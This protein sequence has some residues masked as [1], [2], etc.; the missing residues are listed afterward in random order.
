MKENIMTNDQ[1][2][3]LIEHARYKM[4]LDFSIP[5]NIVADSALLALKD[6]YLY[7]LIADWVEEKNELNKDEMKKEII[8]YTEEILRTK[9][10]I[11]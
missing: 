10:L 7:E 11:K 4:S 3:Q 6:K 2:N 1:K 8:N 5:S 9:K